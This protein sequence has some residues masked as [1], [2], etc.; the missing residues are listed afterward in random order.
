MVGDSLA[1]D[2]E[3]LGIADLHSRYFDEKR[4]LS[5]NLNALEIFSAPDSQINDEIAVIGMGC[6]YPDADS[7]E[8]FWENIVSKKY[9]IREMPAAR[10]DPGALF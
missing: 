7:P 10:L 9:S 2:C 1:F 8:K 5:Q 6:I 4:V 3:P